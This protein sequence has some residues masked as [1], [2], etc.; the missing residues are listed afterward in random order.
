MNGLDV[1]SEAE[2]SYLGDF[3]GHLDAFGARSNM[4]LS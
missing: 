4:I 1:K 2:L 3:G